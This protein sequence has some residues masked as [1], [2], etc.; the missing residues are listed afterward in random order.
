[1]KNISSLLKRRQHCIVR[2]SKMII[3][4]ISYLLI[5]LFVYTATNKI[6]TV[7]SFEQTLHRLPIVGQ[8]SFILAYL[9]PI[10]E[11]GCA[12]LLI[13]PKTLRVGLIASQIMLFGF[14]FYLAY[15]LASH[16]KLPCSCGGVISTLSWDQHLYFN[17]SIMICIGIVLR[18]QKKIRVQDNCIDLYK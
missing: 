5:V 15:Q 7:S 18:V 17:L 13:I 11:Y 9:I 8:Y 14:T 4:I 2:R 12:I 16:N 6:L 3:A 1:M 10:I